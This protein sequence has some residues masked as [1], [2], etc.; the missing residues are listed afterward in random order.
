M[1]FD[2]FMTGIV[3]RGC[4]PRRQDVSVLRGGGDDGFLLL[5]CLVFRLARGSPALVKIR[6]F[7]GCCGQNATLYTL[8]D[9]F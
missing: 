8:G 4:L 1:R 5:V 6:F 7:H 2:W 9:A 3:A